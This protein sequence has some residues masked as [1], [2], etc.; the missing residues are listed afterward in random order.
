MEVNRLRV[1]RETLRKILMMIST[2]IDPVFRVL[3]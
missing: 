2:G 3:F 1:R